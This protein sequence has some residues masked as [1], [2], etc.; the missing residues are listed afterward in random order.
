MAILGV[1]VAVFF[2]ELLRRVA[3]FGGLLAHL[4]G[5]PRATHAFLCVSSEFSLSVS[6]RFAMC[7]VLVARLR[8]VSLAVCDLGRVVS[9]FFL[10][11]L[12]IVDDQRF[13]ASSERVS[14]FAE[15]PWRFANVGAL[16]AHV[17]GMSQCDSR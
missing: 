12:K 2:A 1:F 13:S 17:C 8:G 5:V 11:S 15:C 4:C 16:L 9:A 10:A 14:F 7:G 3:M 6:V